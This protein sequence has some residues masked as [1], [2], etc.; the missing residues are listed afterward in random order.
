MAATFTYT[1]GNLT[2][3]S[4]TTGT[5]LAVGQT[6]PALITP[7]LGTVASGIISACTSTSM[8]MVTPVLGVAAATSINF[9]QDP[10][11]YYDEG[12]FTPTVTPNF[13]G[14][15]AP[16]YSSQIGIFTRIGRMVYVFIDVTLVP[17]WTTA[18]T[19]L[20]FG[21]LP[22]NLGADLVCGGNVT[23]TSVALTFSASQTMLAVSAAVNTSLI[24]NQ[25]GSASANVA[26]GIANMVSGSTYRFIISGWYMA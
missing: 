16:N 5:G 15:W 1:G 6:S 3:S 2:A 23:G 17:T 26:L 7:A 21:A 10:L 9:G 24:I 25:I 4:G 20:K 14:D 22:F 13:S 19:Y 12:T 11:N 8:T 18:S